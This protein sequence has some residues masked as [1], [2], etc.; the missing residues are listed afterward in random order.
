MQDFKQNKIH[1]LIATTVIEVG[2]DIPNATIIIIENAERFGLSQL[3]QLRGRV[4][5]GDIQSYCIL[6]SDSKNKD[7]LTRLKTLKENI[8]GFKI[9]EEDL[10]LR[11]PGDFIGNRQ[12]GLP[13]LNISN[14]IEDSSTLMETSVIAN[15]ILKKDPY[16]IDPKHSSL[17]KSTE[18]LFNSIDINI[19]N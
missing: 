15:K 12:H 7:S 10:R 6:L 5:R 11:G 2:I 17:K 4:G 13:S 9:S 1:I 18:L 8:D 3:H 16:L 19:F 14:L